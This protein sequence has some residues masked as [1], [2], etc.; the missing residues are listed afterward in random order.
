M[1]EPAA[2]ENRRGEKNHQKEKICRETNCREDTTTQEANRETPET[3]IH[4]PYIGRRPEVRR[5]DIVERQARDT[6]VGERPANRQPTESPNEITIDVHRPTEK[7]HRHRTTERL[8]ETITASSIG[9]ESIV[10]VEIIAMVETTVTAG[11][12]AT[13]ERRETAE[14]IETPESTATA[15]STETVGNTETVESTLESREI[16]SVEIVAESE[17]ENE[18]AKITTSHIGKKRSCPSIPDIVEIRRSRAK[19]ELRATMKASTGIVP[20][21]TH[22]H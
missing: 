9:I 10:T 4:R 20:A 12:I 21:S 15:G 6:P 19:N 5:L 13:F 3:D 1:N 11:S 8:T 18:P 14:S 22:R 16:R 2:S 7:S 17:V